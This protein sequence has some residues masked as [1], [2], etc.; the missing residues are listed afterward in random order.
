MQSTGI[1]LAL[2]WG[3]ALGLLTLSGLGLL[4]LVRPRLGLD[5]I[6]ALA[7]AAGLSA[8]LIVALF[9]LAT[10]L[11][12]RLTPASLAAV[13]IL[14][15]AFALAWGVKRRARSSLSR[16]SLTGRL[17]AAAPF[18]AFVILFALTLA[19]R[20]WA[21]RNLVVPAWVDSVH[22]ALISQLI[23]AQGRLPDS[24]LPY[25]PTEATTYHFGFHA[26]AAAL[27][28]LSGLSV[29]QAILI[30]GQ[31][32]NALMVPATYLFARRLT[33]DRLAALIASLLVGLVTTMPAYYV[34]WG[35][36]TQLAGLVILPALLSLLFHRS[37][38]LR[39]A[40]LAGLLLTGLLVTHYRVLAFVV[41]FI[42]AYVAILGIFG[43]SP[44]EQA[45]F[46]PARTVMVRAGVI[47]LAVTALSGAW[48]VPVAVD[49]W[50]RAFR[51]W[52]NPAASDSPLW[53]YITSYWDTFVLALAGLGAA[54]GLYQRRRFAA[55]LVLWIGLLFLLAN[56]ARLGLPGGALVNNT[57][58]LISLFLPLATLC[59]YSL[60]QVITA[61]IRVAPPRW[62]PVVSLIS[63]A[64]LG[65]AGLVGTTWT[66][67]ILNPSTVLFTAADQA[68]MNWIARSTPPDAVFAINTMLWQTSTY[69]GSDGG[70]WIPI[71]TGRRTTVPPALY[72]LGPRAYVLEI[73]GLAHSIEAT[74]P[75][76]DGLWRVLHEHSIGYVY[77]GPRGGPLKV[78]VLLDSPCYQPRYAQAGAWIFEVM[79]CQSQ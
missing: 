48:L 51:T 70:A 39:E 2:A 5:P 15:T 38:G 35:R 17:L 22:H 49:L 29:P 40:L 8:S 3:L 31:V 69:A 32:L 56:P 24:F 53:Y 58:V 13:L 9:L 78:S 75:D 74:A 46:A 4:A 42:A 77:I 60:A 11:R 28:W 62:R 64:A 67:N 66:A 44:S 52:G 14:C 10:E 7:L 54:W 41:S 27:H 20:L 57:S 59:G 26:I 55:V 72:V 6:E 33:G 25:L 34:S 63:A 50:W 1:P 45:E 21:V 30:A 73:N 36:Y 18:V 37:L 16:F 71:L 65:S 79:Q 12:L 43:R 61:L 47:G 68:A 23:A 19:T 76:A